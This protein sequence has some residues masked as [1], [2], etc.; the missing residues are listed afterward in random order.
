ME[1]AVIFVWM[2]IQLPAV[3]RCICTDDMIF[4]TF[5]KMK[6]TFYVYIYIYKTSRSAPSA[7]KEK[8]LGVQN[9]SSV[10]QCC[11]CMFSV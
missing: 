7:H 2:Q 11:K 8:I 9:A 3:L 6:Q 5:F 10:L 4:T 1:H